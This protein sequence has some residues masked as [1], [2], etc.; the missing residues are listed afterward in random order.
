MNREEQLEF[1]KTC[2]NRKLDLKK[3]LLCGLT[4]QYADFENTCKDF[5][6]DTKEA[7]RHLNLKLA[8]TGNYEI[9]SSTDYKKNKDQGTLIAMIGMLIAIITHAIANEIGFFILPYGAV[10]W[11][12]IQYFK[13]VEQEKVFMEN[14]KK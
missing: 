10:I 9:G 1:C 2:K 6:E 8:S 11:G 3:G 5:H 14:K 7:E 4:N 12:G 13:G